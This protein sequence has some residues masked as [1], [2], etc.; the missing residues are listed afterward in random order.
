MQLRIPLVTFVFVCA[1]TAAPAPNQT[2]CS[3]PKIWAPV[4]G[5]DRHTYPSSCVMKCKGTMATNKINFQRT[6]IVN[7]HQ[8]N[9]FASMLF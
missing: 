3:C 8:M 7:S 6:S 5:E 9:G 2:E 1:A 4:C